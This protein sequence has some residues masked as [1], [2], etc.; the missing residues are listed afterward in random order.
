MPNR[1][2]TDR[3]TYLLKGQE[4]EWVRQDN[5]AHMTIKF[6]TGPVLYIGLQPAS[7]ELDVSIVGGSDCSEDWISH[8][9]DP[10]APRPASRK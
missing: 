7:E 10:R 9:E 5:D 6:K 8:A 4:V 3:L 2:V 1:H